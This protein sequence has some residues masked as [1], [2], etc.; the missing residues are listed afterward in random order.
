MRGFNIRYQP[1]YNGFFSMIDN[2]ADDLNERKNRFDKSDLLEQ[3]FE[4]ITDGRIRWVDLEGCDHI[5]EESGTKFEMKSQKFCLYTKTGSLK[6]KTTSA[7]KLTNTLQNGENKVLKATSDWLIIVDTGNEKSYSVAIISYKKVVD[8]YSEKLDDGFKCQ[9]P[10]SELIFLA[11]P[12]QISLS[13]VECK[14]YSE[15]KRRLQ[16]EYI[17]AFLN[18]TKMPN[19]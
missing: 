2:I 14:S 17:D 13:I 6:K 18:K 3:C 8:K 10:I 12:S 15:E 1:N 5:D 19:V 9:I 16:S 7:L 11:I 4:Q